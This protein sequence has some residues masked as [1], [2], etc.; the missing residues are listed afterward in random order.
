MYGGVSRLVGAPVPMHST[1]NRNADDYPD[2]NP[3]SGPIIN[4]RMKARRD[5]CLKNLPTLWYASTAVRVMRHRA[6]G[7]SR[8]EFS[9]LSGH[10]RPPV[11]DAAAVKVVPSGP[12]VIAA[13]SWEHPHRSWYSTPAPTADPATAP[14]RDPATASGRKLAREESQPVSL[15]S[16][17]PKPVSLSVPLKSGSV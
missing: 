14:T 12:A 10:R 1:S 13:L 4:Q 7:I 11:S 5:S 2:T 9:A 3:A 17:I 6:E 16:S 8:S 15:H